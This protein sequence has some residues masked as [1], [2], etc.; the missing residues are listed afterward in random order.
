MQ[1]VKNAAIFSF[2]ALVFV[3]V[4]LLYTSCL[5]TQG[6]LPK[7]TSG[8]D[9]ILVIKLNR[10]GTADIHSDYILYT[11]EGGTIKV[12]TKRRYIFRKGLSPGTHTINSV[13]AVSREY[14]GFSS[15]FDTPE[16][17]FEI[18]PGKITILPAEFQIVMD[19]T[20]QMHTFAKLHSAQITAIKNDL[21][22]YLNY[23]LWNGFA[24]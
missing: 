9:T 4:L 8:A 11:K 1:L 2:A 14:E 20:T 13:K 5:S 23:D 12:N 17:P 3:S 21:A 10:T 19:E 22:E 24:P 18:V 6:T 16:I 15:T 7:P